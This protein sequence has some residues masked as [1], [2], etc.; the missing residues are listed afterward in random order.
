[1]KFLSTLFFAL[2]IL[3][4][5]ASN[6]HGEIHQFKQPDGTVVD[7]KLYG[8]E[9]YIRA[10][11]LDGFTLIRDKA[12]NWIYYANV[13]SDR[14]EL[15][16]TDIK[17]LGQQNNIFSLRSDI[18]LPQHLDISPESY[19]KI[20]DDNA[21]KM[22]NQP[23]MAAVQ[24][25]YG[26]QNRADKVLEGNLKG[27]CIVIDFSDE[28]N[29]LGIEEYEN[30]CNGLNYTKYSNNGSLRQYYLDV[31][32]GLLDYEN[33]V[34]GIFRAP[35]TFQEYDD[36]PYAQ[37][38]Q[39]ILGLTLKWIDEQGFDFSNLSTDENGTIMAI[40]MMYTGNPPEW[41]QGM[42]YHQGYYGAFQADG[43]RTGRYNTS[44]AA[45]PLSIG[46]VVHENGHMI[47]QWPDTYKYDNTTGPDG[48]GAF[49]V[50]C[51]TGPEH[52]PVLPNPYFIN[53][54]GW[55]H[56][57]E[58][59]DL[60]TRLRDTANIYSSYIYR[61]KANE[62]EFYIFQNRL[63]QGRSAGIP[64]EG[65]TIW[66]IDRDGDNQTEHHETY[67]VHNNN[68]I[69]EH[70]GACFRKGRN[71][72]FNF[73][74]TPN[75]DWY[76]GNPSGLRLWN[77]GEKN[78]EMQYNIGRGPAISV[79][80]LSHT[81]DSN[82]D[83]QIIGGET[84]DLNVNL[85][86]LDLGLSTTSVVR[87]KAVGPNASYVTVINPVIQPGDIEPNATISVSF[88]ISLEPGT[89]DYT[90]L[91]FRFEA[92]ED[93]RIAFVEK[94]IST[95]FVYLM[96][97]IQVSSCSA[98]YL[99][100]GG[101]DAYDNNIDYVQTFYPADPNGKVS[102]EFVEFNVEF[103]SGCNNDY[104]RVFNG[105]DISGAVPKKYCGETL[106]PKIVSTDPSGALTFQFH[107]G[108]F[109]VSPGWKA[110]INCEF[111][112]K[113]NKTKDGL[114]A[115]IYPNPTHDKIHI[116][117][118]KIANYNITIMDMMGNKIKDYDLKNDDVLT[119]PLNNLV[120]GVYNVQI[121]SGQNFTTKKLIIQ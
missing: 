119:L 52:N 12:T 44:P 72:E 96:D 26:N 97:S 24:K 109:N 108:L 104:L 92:E 11:G 75:S 14:T 27:L 99:D 15:V 64:D 2:F 9:F 93:D 60:N 47:G 18:G 69:N 22:F 120:S 112:L 56:A 28:V 76:D 45:A 40:N 29:P 114:I 94:E 90:V 42:W 33:V 25:G 77:F 37:G 23:S 4:L 100:P 55:G 6:Y 106:P 110:F 66:H 17:Y 43:V 20:M 83:G 10:E 13:S 74:S 30:L 8:S 81:N 95:G 5:S 61:N 71:E 7:V 88:Q 85:T 68:N 65:L 82:G 121:V 70:S 78:A 35:K 118:G 115:N 101:L 63:K 102:V 16:A 21:H 32:G 98:L 19:N 113:N 111:P 103:G 87:C 105:P 79:A 59:N 39:E 117:F 36:M 107:S 38:A 58:V 46:T 57:L 51:A 84:F 3:T 34:Y 50:M 54:V 73:D 67:L 80:Y 91:K 48:I 86:N 41:A 116:T 53:R 31:S 62:R 49:D 1:M 89:P